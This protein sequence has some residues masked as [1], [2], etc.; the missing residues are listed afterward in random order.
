MRMKCIRIF[1]EMWASP[2]WPVSS[3]TRNRAFGRGSTT[4]PSTSIASSF[5]VCPVFFFAIGLLPAFPR[6]GT[7]EDLGTL[8]GD[9]DRVLKVGGQGAILTHGRPLILEDGQLRGPGG[10]HRL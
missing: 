4:V 2:L 3:S 10:D 7:R 1:P 6:I 8:V 5:L 9:G